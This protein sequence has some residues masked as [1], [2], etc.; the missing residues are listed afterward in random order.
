MIIHVVRGD[1]E[2]PIGD[3]IAI[4]Q[5]LML[6]NPL[7]LKKPQVV[8]VNKIDLPEVRRKLDSLTAQIKRLCGHSRVMGI[9]AITGERVRE[10]MQRT[11]R[12]LQSLPVSDDLMHLTLGE[13]ERVT[14]D[15][16]IVDDSFE[17]FTNPNIPN[18]FQV[19]GKKIEKMVSMTNWDYY[20]AIQRFHRILEA[21]GINSALKK[22]GAENGDT[23]MIGEWDFNFYDR[24]T[25]WVG[26]LGMEN[27][28]PRKRPLTKELM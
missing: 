27:I 14:F 20:E 18:T 12:M 25:L 11:H 8:V 15:E 4:N 19:V 3:F 21:E 13:E 17:I 5:E 6:Y 23:I 24:A 22:R 26:E 7:L 9:S 10:L 16:E 28:N 1:S 2:D